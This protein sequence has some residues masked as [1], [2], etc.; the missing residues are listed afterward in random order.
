MEVNKCCN[1]IVVRNSYYSVEL[2]CALLK[3]LRGNK[4]K[5]YKKKKKEK[6]KEGGDKSGSPHCLIIP[7]VTLPKHKYY[8][9]SKVIVL[10]VRVKL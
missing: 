6:K 5:I 2:L 9:I 3:E 4:G 1:F 7:N 10:N 8:F